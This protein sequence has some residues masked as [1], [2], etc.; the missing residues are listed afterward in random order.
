MDIQAP[1][2]SPDGRQIAFLRVSRQGVKSLFI[3]ALDG[4]AD[5]LTRI[6]IGR[7]EPGPPAWDSR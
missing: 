6:P 1:T 5:T 7:G 4:G 3:L 2:W